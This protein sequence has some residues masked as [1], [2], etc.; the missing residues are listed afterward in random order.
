MK[1]IP[2]TIGEIKYDHFGGRTVNADKMWKLY[3]RTKANYY[4]QSVYYLS[5]LS[6]IESKYSSFE[7]GKSGDEE[8]MTQKEY[9]H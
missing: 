8:L 4:H 9:R 6:D 2:V 7:V 1:I 3:E 5:I